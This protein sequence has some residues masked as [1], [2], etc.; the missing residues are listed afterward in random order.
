M[1]SG[2]LRGPR[3]YKG[4]LRGS[5]KSLGAFGVPMGQIKSG[6]RVLGGPRG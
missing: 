4:I 1:S 6:P 3:G 2:I 5:M